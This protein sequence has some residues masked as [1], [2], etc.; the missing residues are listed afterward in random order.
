MGGPS[1]APASRRLCRR[2][3]LRHR[4]PMPWHG[5]EDHGDSASECGARDDESPSRS[6]HRYHVS[7]R[8]NSSR[9]TIGLAELAGRGA[10]RG[11]AETTRAD[12]PRA[13]PRHRVHESRSPLA[14]CALSRVCLPSSRPCGRIREEAPG[15]RPRVTR[16][17]SD[18]EGGTPAYRPRIRN[19]L[20]MKE[21]VP[22]TR[23]TN[24]FEADM[25]HQRPLYSRF[26]WG[27]VSETCHL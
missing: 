4:G 16:Q 18:P 6:H 14:R 23:V 2:D 20:R 8:T 1:E 11:W 26:R 24:S 22:V 25:V 15:N 5:S 9:P 19:G 10:G 13:R 17:V 27:S 21:P 7:T 3:C 12:G